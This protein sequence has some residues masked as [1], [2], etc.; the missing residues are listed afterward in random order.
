MIEVERKFLYP[1]EGTEHL[2]LGTTPLKSKTNSDRY[3]DTRDFKLTAREWWLRERNGRFELKI[4][5]K[6]KHDGSP[7]DVFDELETDDEIYTALELIQT[8][9]GLS[10][11]LSNAGFFPFA[12][13]TTSRNSY[14]IGEFQIDIDTTQSETND[15]PLV[16]SSAPFVH[17]IVEI[18]IMVEDESD[19]AAAQ[20][21]IDDFARARGL[22]LEKI[23][24]KLLAYIRK[25]NPI[26]FEI[27]R[28][29]NIAT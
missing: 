2:L 16:E 15:S 17:T 21:K 4:A 27:L 25:N 20:Q 6:Q 1:T 10:T 18:E 8:P 19:I 26:Q 12:H 24:G 23:D 29:N 3:F 22:S 28:K 14:T 9:L 13:L 7:S 11:D 5:K